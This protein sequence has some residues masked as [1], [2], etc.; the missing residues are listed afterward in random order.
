MNKLLSA[1]FVALSLQLVVPMSTQTMLA[2]N[3]SQVTAHRG[4]SAEAPENTMAAF[5]QA[6]KDRAGLSELDVQETSDDVVMVMHDDSVY[7]TTGIRKNMWETTS[8]ELKAADAGS[9]KSAKYKGEH[10]PTLEEVIQAAKGHMKLNI[11]LKN[12]GHSKRLVERTVAL[13]EANDFVKD[14]IITSFDAQFLHRVKELNPAIKT[15]LIVGQKPSDWE[16][17]LSSTN[18]DVI[19]AAYTLVN[20]RFVDQCTE[21]R[22]EVYVWTVNDARMMRQMLALGVASIITNEPA[23]LT[24]LMSQEL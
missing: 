8:A 21:H 9:W 24:E 16:P 20:G 22:K 2:D 6:I 1:L 4:S 19:S 17:I 14:C 23:K 10:V 18:Y 15:G 3:Y 7:R 12:N 11:E 5:R 13:I